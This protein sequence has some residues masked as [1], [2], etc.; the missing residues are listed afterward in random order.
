VIS[1]GMAD[2]LRSLRHGDGTT[3]AAACARALE[4]D[5]VAVSLL[6]GAGRGADPEPLWRSPDAAADFEELQFTLGV[7]PGPDAARSGTAVLAPD[8]GAVRADRWPG[9][10]AEARKIG[11]GG[12]CCF[13]LG[14]GAIRS[15][16]PPGPVPRIRTMHGGQREGRR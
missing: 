16:M 3:L 5:G 15:A 12:A 8:L 10:A 6:V 1:D 7:G 4:A 13:P 9:L 14:L 11:V 2:V